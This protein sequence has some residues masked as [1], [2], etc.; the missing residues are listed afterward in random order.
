[1]FKGLLKCTS[2]Q[3]EEI[4][5]VVKDFQ[6]ELL[7]RPS[8]EKLGLVR[9]VATVKTLDPITEFPT[10]FNGLGQLDGEYTISL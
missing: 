4:I 2:R 3:T 5:Y 10:L 9:C 6:T 7:G 1:M 8:I